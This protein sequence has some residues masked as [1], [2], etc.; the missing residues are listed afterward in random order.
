MGTVVFVFQGEGVVHEQ[1][2]Y[3]ILN[4]KVRLQG[5]SFR[6]SRF[7]LNVD[8]VYVH[9]VGLGSLRLSHLDPGTVDTSKNFICYICI[10]L[11]NVLKFSYMSTVIKQVKGTKEEVTVNKN[12]QRKDRNLCIRHV[13][14]RISLVSPFFRSLWEM[15]NGT[16]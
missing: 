14:V 12:V 9:G 10:S 1:I 2:N 5:I 16:T 6:H 13:Y 11:F 15:T 7:T 3:P 8:D 4:M